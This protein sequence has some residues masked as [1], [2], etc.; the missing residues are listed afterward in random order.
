MQY[1]RAN[2]IAQNNSKT[3][4][5]LVVYC[6]LPAGAPLPFGALPDSW[7]GWLLGML[8]TVAIPLLTNKWGT[9]LKWTSKNKEKIESTVQTVENIVEAVEDVAEK[10]EKISEDILDDLPEG[11]LKNAVSRIEN[12]AEKIAKDAHQIDNMIDK[13]QEAEEQF[14][15]CIEEGKA[16]KEAKVKKEI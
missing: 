11:N 13:V 5:N 9:V 2:K 7:K 15:A 12:A 6:N 16:A 14:E 4:R 8:F 1:F 10:V 3:K